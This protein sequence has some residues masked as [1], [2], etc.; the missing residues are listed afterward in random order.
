[1]ESTVIRGS[2]ILQRWSLVFCMHLKCFASAFL[3]R[4]SR[5]TGQYWQLVLRASR[6]L[7]AY[8]PYSWLSTH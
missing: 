5:T 6:L 3:H 1:M 8:V 4:A 2:M 7:V